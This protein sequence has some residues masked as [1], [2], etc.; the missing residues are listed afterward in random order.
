MRA[1][2]IKA[3]LGDIRHKKKAARENPGKTA[4]MGE[5]RNKWRIFVQMIQT[6]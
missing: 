4:N 6:M 1:E 5:V 2:H 3:W